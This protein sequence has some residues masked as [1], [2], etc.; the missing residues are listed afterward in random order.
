M[1]LLLILICEVAIRLIYGADFEGAAPPLRLMLP[2]ELLEAAATVLWAGMLAANRP[3]LSTAAYLPSAVVTIIGLLIFL[4]SGGIMA[5]AG[6]TTVAYSTSFVITVIL[7][8]RVAG[9]EWKHFL[10]PPPLPA[11]PVMPIEE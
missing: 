11:E 3:F 7:Y 10:K 8:R 6:V 5:A 4:Q 2:G 1:A 9:L